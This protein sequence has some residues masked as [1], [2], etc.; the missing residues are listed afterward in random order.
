MSRW[1]TAQLSPFF[2]AAYFQYGGED[3]DWDPMWY[4]AGLEGFAYLKSSRSVY[5]RVS[6][7]VDLQA[8]ME[9]GGLSDPAPR[10]DGQRWELYIGLGH[11]Y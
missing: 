2:D 9:G 5:L 7:G 6:F 8:M 10:D 4:G 3:D 1:F 11:H